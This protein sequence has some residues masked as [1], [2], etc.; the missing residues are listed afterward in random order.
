MLPKK[1]QYNW[2]YVGKKTINAIE[3]LKMV[4][5]KRTWK[6]LKRI[7]YLRTKVIVYNT[8]A[9]TKGKN[10][11]NSTG[12]LCNARNTPNIRNF[13]FFSISAKKAI[14]FMLER[15]Y[16]TKVWQFETSCSQINEH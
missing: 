1:G 4:L 16:T 14:T 7:P 11:A 10:T 13:Q 2:G 3:N 12:V 6:N 8:H 15:K 5:Y 9:H